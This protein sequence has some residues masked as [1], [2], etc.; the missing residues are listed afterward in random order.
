MKKI[1]CIVLAGVLG[2]ASFTRAQ[3]RALQQ[4]IQGKKHFWE[5]R[6]DQAGAA[7]KE[8]IGVPDVKSEYLFEAYLYLGFVLTRQNAAASDVN[9]A[10]EQA[11]KIDPKR[12]LDEL[13]IPPDLA[14]RFNA[15]RDQLVGCLYVST[16]PPDAKLVVVMEDSVIYSASSPRLLCELLSKKYQILVTKDGYD[17]Q[18]LPLELTGGKVDSLTVSLAGST[19]AQK[20]KKGMLKWVARG[21]IVAAA[22]AVIYITV[23]DSG[24]TEEIPTLPGPPDRPSTN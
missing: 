2:I 18:F 12:K 9:N 16:E 10:F 4:L 8:V 23:L 19:T 24:G 21:G 20:Q 6:F 11:I 22:G 15:A 14:A 13:V 5:A 17:Q 3:D 7:L 1:V